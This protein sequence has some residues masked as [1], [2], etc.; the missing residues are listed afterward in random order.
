MPT[1]FRLF[2]QS[3]ATVTNRLQ[4]RE[5]IFLYKYIISSEEIFFNQC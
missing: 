1:Y 3:E 2:Q 5:V 4:A